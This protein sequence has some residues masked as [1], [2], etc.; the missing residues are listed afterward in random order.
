MTLLFHYLEKTIQS[1]F[2]FLLLFFLAGF[3]FFCSLGNHPFTTDDEG[4]FSEIGRE[5]IES[6][7][8]QQ[9][10][11]QK[12]NG[13]TYTKKPPLFPILIASSYTLWNE[14]SEF[15]ALFPSALFGFLTA[16]VSFLFWRHIFGQRLAFI[17]TLILITIY[18]VVDQARSPQVDMV[19][20]FFLVTALFSAYLY[21][22]QPKPKAIWPILF[23]ISSAFATLTKGPIGL[24]L[25]CLIVGLDILITNRWHRFFSFKLLL[26]SL[27]YIVIIGCW[28][29][30]LIPNAPEGY[31]R[32]LFIE[33]NVTR[34]VDA[35][36]HKESFFFYIPAFLQDFLPWTLFL[37]L[38][39]IKRSWRENRTGHSIHFFWIWFIAIFVFFTLSD[40]KREIY[41][42]PLYPAIAFLLA[43][44]CNN[45][46]KKWLSLFATISFL[47][48][49][50]APLALNQYHHYKDK[51][52]GHPKEQIQT[53]I[54]E[55]GTAPLRSF[56]GMEPVFLFYAKQV[57]SELYSEEEVNAYFNTEQRAYLLI[58]DNG[59]ETHQKV[60]QK[61][62]NHFT[63]SYG[64]DQYILL[65]NQP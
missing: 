4:R 52:K 16:L 1:K 15:S 38:L 29:L 26:G 19:L 58:L 49:L 17:S 9:W 63:F 41:L 57:I 10:V 36:D 53:M 64:K 55:V 31:L 33:Q 54:K 56:R 14:V 45:Q 42:L 60:I 35:F 30:Y 34:Y 24:L 44:G 28:I 27:F 22:H 18:K 32:E 40:S 43:N 65:S 8:S 6:D 12:L 50:I 3:V 59:I 2:S 37:P 39:F 48:I 25:P 61:W 46:T 23:F 51:R 5:I 21:L 47:F 13:Q 11:I 20:L 62:P 7:S